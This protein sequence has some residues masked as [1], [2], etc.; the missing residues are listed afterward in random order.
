MNRNDKEDETATIVATAVVAILYTTVQRSVLHQYS[1]S[2]CAG[3]DS[4]KRMDIITSLLV[5]YA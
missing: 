4:Q 2:V 1:T 3:T 5:M